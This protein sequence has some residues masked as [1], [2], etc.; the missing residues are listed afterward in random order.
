M[1]PR[2]TYSFSVNN[3]S[4]HGFWVIEPKNGQDRFEPPKSQIKSILLTFCKNTSNVLHEQ[5]HKFI[6]DKN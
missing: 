2:I 6:A 3:Q 1:G 4:K 5:K